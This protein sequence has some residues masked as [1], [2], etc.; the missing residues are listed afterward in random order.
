MACN[1][2]HT[3]SLSYTINGAVRGLIVDNKTVNLQPFER[4][5]FDFGNGSRV[6][7]RPEITVHYSMADDDDDDGDCAI[8]HRLT[9]VRA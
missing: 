2:G 6:A 1:H 7:F 3:T 8:C 4:D 5:D 9:A